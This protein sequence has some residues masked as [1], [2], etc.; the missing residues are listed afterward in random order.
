M[1]W[2]GLLYQFK[3]KYW[4]LKMKYLVTGAAGFIGSVVVRLFLR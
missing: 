1:K 2:D 3:N 4:T